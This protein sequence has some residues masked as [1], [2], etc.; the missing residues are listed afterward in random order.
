M[1]NIPVALDK[2]AKLGSFTDAVGL[3]FK[4]NLLVIPASSAAPSGKALLR[5]V[6]ET[7]D[8]GTT[9]IVKTGDC[10]GEGDKARAEVL[11]IKCSAGFTVKDFTSQAPS[12][13]EVAS[14][15]SLDLGTLP[16][17]AQVKI[18]TSMDPDP[19][20]ARA[21]QLAATDSG[22]G[23]ISI[24]Y[25]INVE[26]TNLKNG[27]DIKSAAVTMVVGKDWVKENG[28][29]EVIRIMRYD[30]ETKAQQVLETRFRGYDEKGR[31]IFEGISPDGLSVF[32]LAGK[33]PVSTI[34]EGSSRG[35]IIGLIAGM[36]IVVIAVWFYI[37]KRRKVRK[38]VKETSA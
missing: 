2:G 21:F 23:N 6:D 36:A 27:T 31:A 37:A 24:A 30:L 32:G 10:I 22:L 12:L 38:G 20:A 1:V 16:D 4:D 28:G 5:I 11:A 33:K 13:G 7:K 29:I 35:W 19:L 25:T 3:T 34:T 14:T 18:T 15:V 17:G 8:L 9:I 26:K